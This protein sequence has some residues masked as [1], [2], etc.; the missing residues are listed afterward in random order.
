[1]E[2]QEMRIEVDKRKVKGCLDPF[3]KE[4]ITFEDNDDLELKINAIYNKLDEDGSAGLDFTE[5]QRGI[6]DLAMNIHVT[7]DDFDIITE[8]GKH[9]NRNA[10]FNREQF[11]EMMRGELW[12][13]SRRQLTNVLSLS[14]SRDFAGTILMLKLFEN[15][16]IH[17]TN[18][19]TS[20]VDHQQG[21]IQE[22]CALLKIL[23][24][25]VAS[26]KESMLQG[27]LTPNGGP[28][29]SPS[30]EKSYELHLTE[31]LSFTDIKDDANEI[32]QDAPLK[33]QL[34]QRQGEINTLLAE[35]QK[36]KQEVKRLSEALAAEKRVSGALKRC[37][38]QRTE[39]GVRRKPPPSPGQAEV[40][41]AS[42]AATA[43]ESSLLPL[44]AGSNMSLSFDRAAAWSTRAG[45]PRTKTRGSIQTENHPPR[46]TTCRRPSGCATRSASSCTACRRS[47]SSCCR[48]RCSSWC[49]Q[50]TWPTT[51]RGCAVPS[52]IGHT[53]SH[54]CCAAKILHKL[55]LM[56]A[57]SRA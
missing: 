53:G 14:E 55:N 33:T 19:L 52:A 39:L 25:D 35:H 3:T 45:L 29:A 5:L 12:R 13:F 56:A 26:I 37:K 11:Q 22:S 28:S 24:V 18:Q 36:L 50:Q 1:V 42:V 51:E 41:Y 10:E 9:L 6:K 2:E 49:W 23:A 40:V 54:C 44:P 4:L 27:P 46:V 30:Y 8:N 48:G 32:T 20:K 43:S 17:E 57:F 47:S 34:V 7:R 38:Q 31:A 16:F 15:E 21:A